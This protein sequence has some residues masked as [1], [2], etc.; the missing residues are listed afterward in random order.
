MAN[1]RRNHEL[2]EA[3]QTIRDMAAALIR[4]RRP[5]GNP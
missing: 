2:T 4:N 1:N 5:E 3:M